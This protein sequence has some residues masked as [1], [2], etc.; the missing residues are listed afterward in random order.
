MRI[1]IYNGNIIN[2]IDTKNRHGYYENSIYYEYKIAGQNGLLT[3]PG[4]MSKV[5]L[6]AGDIKEPHFAHID[7]ER[8]CEYDRENSKS[9]E[10]K[11]GENILYYWLNEQYKGHVFID[12]KYDNRFS[13]VSL[14]YKGNTYAFNYIRNERVLNEWDKKRKDYLESGIIDLYFFSFKEFDELKNS[15]IQFKRTVQ[16]YTKDNTIKMINTDNNKL[17]LMRFI[18]FYDD[19]NNLFYSKLSTREYEIYDIKFT[20]DGQL[21]TNFEEEFSKDYRQ[22]KEIAEKILKEKI[23]KAKE[24][25]EIKQQQISIDYHNGLKSI[26]QSL[27]KV[28]PKRADDLN[29][30]PDS[31][32]DINRDK[33]TNPEGLTPKE[34]DDEVKKYISNRTKEDFVWKL[35][36]A[37]PII[38]LQCRYCRNYFSEEHCKPVKPHF[39]ICNS[40]R[41]IYKK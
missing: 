8:E 36:K 11:K 24:K 40:C 15:E 19:E 38:L 18:E 27:I 34:L 32:V 29:E 31:F 39:G 28:K 22:H 9:D 14:E 33:Y 10:Q 3:C 37:N 1:A 17:I 25:K 12:K 35:G 16:Q 41:I 2:A 26:Q 30:I 5:I 13:N 21:V 4:C 20:P 7:T 23:Q 6:K